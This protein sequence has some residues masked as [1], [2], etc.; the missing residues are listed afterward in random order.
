MSEPFIAEIRMFG[1]NFPPAEWSYCSGQLMAISQNT[2]LFSLVGTIYGGD[3]RTSF[4]VPNLQGRA[5]MHWGTAPG[6]TPRP[7]GQR[8]GS[9]DVTLVESE[10]PAHTHTVTGLTAKGD[11]EVAQNNA[12]LAVDVNAGYRLRFVNANPTQMTSMSPSMLTVAG[13]SYEHQNQ[14]PYTVVSFCIA[15][16]GIYPSRN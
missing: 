7:I 6:L 8:A 5:P 16:T 11:I 9:P 1:N 15:L 12:Y 10:I 4:G 14:Q 2:A 3:G 13:Q